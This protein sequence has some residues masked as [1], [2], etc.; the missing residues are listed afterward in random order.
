M[1][2]V[3][4]SEILLTS[5][6]ALIVLGP[7][8]LP[9]V[10]R[11]VGNWMGRARVMARQLTEQ[12]EREVSAEELLKT[13]SKQAGAD[14]AGA[15]TSGASAPAAFDT[16]CACRCRTQ[17]PR[18]PPARAARQRTAGSL[19]ASAAAVKARTGTQARQRINELMRSPANRAVQKAR[20]SHLLSCA[21]AS[22]R[23]WRWAF[24]SC[25]A[26]TTAN[27]LFT[28]VADVGLQN[29]RRAHP[30]A[31]GVVSPFS[32]PSRWRCCSIGAA[33][34]SFF[35]KPGH[36]SSPVQ[37]RRSWRCPARLSIILF[38]L[39]AAFATTRSSR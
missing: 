21:I 22:S 18:R 37:A 10:A 5:A 20:D 4:F 35:T 15:G 8:R 3:G 34:P 33:I 25:L 6:I 23:R 26:C 2:D 13:R 27:P 36:S 30:T 7:E 39:G 12:L 9:K 38:Y 28:F 32:V 17:T 16:S 1:L 31:T 11:Q 19:L 29:C 14:N 24:V